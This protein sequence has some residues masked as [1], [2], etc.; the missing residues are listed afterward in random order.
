LNPAFA[1]TATSAA[2][3]YGN[4][5]YLNFMN[6][7][8]FDQTDNGYFGAIGGAFGA[9]VSPLLDL[10]KPSRKEN[11]IGTMRPYQNPQS[12]GQG[13]Y[14]FNPNEILAP[15]IRETYEESKNHLN[16]NRGQ[17][18]NAYLSTPNQA[19]FTTRSEV[20]NNDYTGTAASQNP[21]HRQYDAEYNQRNNDLKSSTLVG[22]MPAGNTNYFQNEILVESNAQKDRDLRNV[23]EAIPSKPAQAPERF[24]IGE[25][26]GQVNELYSGTSYDRNQ[27]YV[28]DAL[29]GNPYTHNVIHGL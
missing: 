22:H 3:D 28:L 21:L 25:Q 17:Q 8:S 13:T 26:Q 5:S 15:T 16:V 9:A 24:M 14:I 7:R 27:E 19:A 12:K 29:Q 6:N 11:V 20:N 23:R 4:G 2:S 18:G 1:K 10:L